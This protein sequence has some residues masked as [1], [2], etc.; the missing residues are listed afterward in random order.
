L[1]SITPLAAHC[2]SR[3]TYRCQKT[4]VACRI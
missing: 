4:S 1:M 3:R 2:R